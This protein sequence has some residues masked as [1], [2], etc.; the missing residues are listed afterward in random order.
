M[1]GS[2]VPYLLPRESFAQEHGDWMRW[3]G[4]VHGGELTLVTVIQVPQG[5]CPAQERLT[6][7]RK[8]EICCKELTKMHSWVT[9][10]NSYSASEQVSIW[11]LS[12]SL[13]RLV[14]PEKGL[15]ILM[16]F[17]CERGW[18]RLTPQL[19]RNIQTPPLTLQNSKH[20]PHPDSPPFAYYFPP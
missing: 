16:L 8:T 20:L 1:A 19:V 5:M 9:R 11:Y 13:C 18:E 14:E 10:R 17:V 3:R 12:S 15:L 2:G 6:T 7:Y 4:Q